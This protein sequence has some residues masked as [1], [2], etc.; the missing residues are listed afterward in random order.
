MS[1]EKGQVEGKRIGA[2]AREVLEW[3][4]DRPSKAHTIGFI[5]DWLEAGVP[6]VHGAL[7]TLRE[8]GA[9]EHFKGEPG[10]WGITRRGYSLI[11]FDTASEG[12][13]FRMALE[14][15]EMVDETYSGAGYAKKL[16]KKALRDA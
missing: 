3:M 12:V 13:R 5:A 8:Q 2:L 9:V 4:A 15:I 1:T 14:A 10:T 16:A 11:K 7:A 6:K